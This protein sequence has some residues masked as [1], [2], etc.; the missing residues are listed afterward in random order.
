[1]KNLLKLCQQF[2]CD[3]PFLGWKRDD[4]HFIYSPLQTVL[5][6]TA[7]KELSKA[8]SHNLYINLACLSVCSY[9]PTGYQ[10]IFAYSVGLPGPLRLS[11]PAVR[12]I[13]FTVGLSGQKTAVRTFLFRV[14]AKNA[15]QTNTFIG[16][17]ENVS[18]PIRLYAQVECHI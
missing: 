6:T 2:R 4:I 15:K 11:G 9:L 10:D 1:M 5:L 8:P 18:I 13:A 14:S 3:P 12:T 16:F 17:S 7:S